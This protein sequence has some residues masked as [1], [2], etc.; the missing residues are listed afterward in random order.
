M[1]LTDKMLARVTHWTSKLLSYAGRLQLVKTVLFSIQTFW[2]Q[3]FIL[4]K[5]VLK[6]VETI[7]RTFLWTGDTTASRKALIAWEQLC[8]PKAAGG[9]N[10]LHAQTWNKAAICKLL[11]N[12]CKKANK[13]WVRW[14]HEYYLKQQ[15]VW[16]IFPKQASWMLKK[17]F[18]AVDILEEA[19]IDEQQ[20][21]S[22]TTFSIKQVYQKLRGNHL[23]VT[24]RRLVCNNQGAPKWIFILYLALNKRLYTRDRLTQWGITEQLVCPLCGTENETVE[25]LFFK[26]SYSARVWEKIVEWQ[27]YNRYAMEWT[28]EVRN[29]RVFQSKQREPGALI[30]IIA[31]EIMVRGNMQPKLA[32][33]LAR[34]DYYPS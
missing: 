21:N 18:K 5:K 25:H 17:I 13:L 26:C 32:S 33:Q 29:N 14:V 9:L 4:P 3:I 15:S 24:S 6:A 22:I 11:W 34:M 28:D 30:R 23:K 19:G 10:V 8:L 31:Q 7:C 12:L 16:S 1:P 2:A 20:L 27:G